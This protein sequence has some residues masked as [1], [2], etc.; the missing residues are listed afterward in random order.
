MN[1]LDC[2]SWNIKPYLLYILLLQGILIKTKIVG[3]KVNK[4]EIF[5]AVLSG[6]SAWY[7]VCE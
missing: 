3:L 5:V 6:I 1:P 7:F 2:I 4:S